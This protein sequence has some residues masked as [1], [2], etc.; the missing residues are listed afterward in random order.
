MNKIAFKGI[1]ILI[2][3]QMALSMKPSQ[4]FKIG[5][6]PAHGVLSRFNSLAKN[7][8]VHAVSPSKPDEKLSDRIRKVIS[9]DKAV[10]NE[11]LAYNPKGLEAASSN[12]NTPVSIG[13]ELGH[14][15]QDDEFFHEEHLREITVPHPHQ[16]GGEDTSS[17]SKNTAD[18]E[19]HLLNKINVDLGQLTLE[20]DFTSKVITDDP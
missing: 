5:D 17:V 7:Y 1:T 4:Q 13:K 8:N 16:D 12:L 9:Y 6:R 2:F 19:N 20:Q 18:L 10:K 15:N 14:L 3:C 11:K